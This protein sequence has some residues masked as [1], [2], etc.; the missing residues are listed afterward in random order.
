MHPDLLH[1]KASAAHGTSMKRSS[2]IIWLAYALVVTY[3]GSGDGLAARNARKEPAV[4]SSTKNVQSTPQVKPASVARPSKYPAVEATPVKRKSH[5]PVKASKKS[6]PKA[7]VQP[8]TDLMHYGILE[9]SQRYDPRPPADS[10][11][12]PHPQAL[13]L[14]HDHFQELDRNQDG[15][16]DPVERAFGRI[17][18][19]R[20]LHT[21][22]LQ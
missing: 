2:A 5:R 6:V 1:L 18:M 17:D 7:I 3:D 9:N 14:T 13:D 10:T 21:R 20:D 22:T 8:R 19:D 15:K 12:V 16:I 4:F 11:G